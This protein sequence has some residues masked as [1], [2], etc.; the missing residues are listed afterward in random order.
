MTV[1]NLENLQRIF[2][3]LGCLSTFVTISDIVIV[4]VIT[5]G[6]QWR[7]IGQSKEPKI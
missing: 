2:S 7:G 6:A 1:Q 5:V 4:I 3:N